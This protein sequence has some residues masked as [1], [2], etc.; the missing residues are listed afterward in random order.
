M[1]KLFTFFCNLNSG[2]CISNY[3]E[4]KLNKP[5]TYFIFTWKAIIK[6]LENRCNFTKYN[7]AKLN[8]YPI[9]FLTPRALQ[10]DCIHSHRE[11]NW[12]RNHLAFHLG[13]KSPALLLVAGCQVT[14][15]ALFTTS[16]QMMTV[17]KLSMHAFLLFSRSCLT[18]CRSHRAL[19]GCRCGGGPSGDFLRHRLLAVRCISKAQMDL[20]TDLIFFAKQDC[21]GEGRG[22]NDHVGE[23][24]HGYRSLHLVIRRPQ[25]TVILS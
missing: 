18:P 6:H 21:G 16:P 8:M 12:F 22:I 13:D 20:Q 11:S 4:S 10:Y 15:W 1:H 25:L 14:L 24:F 7:T 5:L 2:F 17:N 3:F 19:A 9:F 23:Y